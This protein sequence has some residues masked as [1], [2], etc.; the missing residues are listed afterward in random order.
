MFFFFFAH[1][2]WPVLLIVVQEGPSCWGTY[3]GTL[4]KSVETLA[5]WKRRMGLV[6]KALKWDL[7][8]LG[9]IPSSAMYL[10]NPLG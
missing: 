6:T 2:F 4:Y 1:L 7:G 8:D 10:L 5:G 3:E 9:L